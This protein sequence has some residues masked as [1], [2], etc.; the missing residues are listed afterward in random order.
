M[1]YT[2]HLAPGNALNDLPNVSIALGEELLRVGITTPA[3]LAQIGAEDA[4][5]RLRTAGLHDCIHTL[6]V[7][8]GAVQRTPWRLL[9]SER[10]F[11]LMRFAATTIVRVSA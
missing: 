5:L 6:L 9:P 8:E 1:T 4:W 2:P 10:R 11:E 7:L 3:E